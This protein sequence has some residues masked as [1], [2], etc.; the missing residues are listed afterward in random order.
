MRIL[1]RFFVLLLAGHLVAAEP[2]VLKSAPTAPLTPGTNDAIITKLTARLL[3]RNHYS[4][5]PLDDSMAERFYNRYLNMLDP[6]HFYFLKSDLDEFEPYR[7]TLDELTL[8]RGD[9]RP[10]Y[11]I[12]QRFLQ[13]MKEHTDYVNELLKTEKFEFNT[14]EQFVFN[15]REL[16]RPL[17]LEAAKKLWR[18]YLRFEYLDQK[19]GAASTKLIADK[20]SDR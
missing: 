8:Q 19:L 4:H 2:A 10:A 1:T 14:D 5:H 18:D 16:P 7:H 20:E 6:L 9:T 12:F 3:E 11:A 17:N 15:R 13:R